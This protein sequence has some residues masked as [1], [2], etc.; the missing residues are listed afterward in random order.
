LLTIAIIDLL[1]IESPKTRVQIPI[2]KIQKEKEKS[3]NVTGIVALHKHLIIIYQ[4]CLIEANEQATC[5][6]VSD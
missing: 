6:E 5:S 4:V 2:Q 3:I 1:V